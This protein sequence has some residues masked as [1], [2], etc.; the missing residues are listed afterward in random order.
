MP[1]QKDSTG[2][3]PKP[4]PK[5]KDSVGN[6][7]I[8]DHARK[9]SLDTVAPLIERRRSSI[10]QEAPPPTGR[11]GSVDIFEGC[12]MGRRASINP[13][14]PR[15]EPPSITPETTATG[16]HIINLECRINSEVEP[17]ATWYHMDERIKNGE[18][19]SQGVKKD[20]DAWVAWL[21]LKE[22]KPK[23]AG[24]YTIR[25]QNGA[26]ES[27]ATVFSYVEKNKNAHNNERRPSISDV[28]H[29]EVKTAAVPKL[30][31]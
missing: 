29:Y 27:F 6:Y 1:L 12:P 10:C 7:V 16:S 3:E 28:K 20:G 25:A 15:L 23:D 30:H 9:D 19:V 21:R 14:S 11:R 2:V 26:G 4:A 5:R 8:P 31:V 22:V 24:K 17:V 18:R 13:N